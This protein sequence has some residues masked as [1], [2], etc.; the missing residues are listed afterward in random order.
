MHHTSVP[1]R[2]NT[3]TKASDLCLDIQWLEAFLLGGEN[4]P[5]VDVVLD[6]AVDPLVGGPEAGA[7]GAVDPLVGV[8][9]AGAV[10][11]P[12]GVL[13]AGAVPEVEG[14]GQVGAVVDGQVTSD[15]AVPKVAGSRKRKLKDRNFPK[16]KYRHVFWSRQQKK[17]NVRVK[18]PVTERQSCGTYV[19]EMDAAKAADIILY[20]MYC[21]DSSLKSKLKFNFFT[22]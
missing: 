21:K 19:D 15:E 13:E 18:H 20:D 16:S 22:F 6:G 9:E 7:V 4:V 12:E 17:W 2:A 3:K 5:E 14:T 11:G 8:L 1:C 10:G